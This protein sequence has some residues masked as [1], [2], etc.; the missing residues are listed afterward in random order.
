M[1]TADRYLSEKDV[2]D[3]S[4]SLNRIADLFERDPSRFERYAPLSKLNERL[5]LGGYSDLL[6]IEGLKAQG[7]TAVV[8]LTEHDFEQ[9]DNPAEKT[10]P[11]RPKLIPG[12][13][14]KLAPR[15]PK[16]VLDKRSSE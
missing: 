9:I 12:K 7:I 14:V 4:R 6:D 3:A 5:Y 15:I 11:G 2:A 16:I 10:A 8:N 1:T 13:L